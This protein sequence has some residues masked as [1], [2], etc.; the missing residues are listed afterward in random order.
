MNPVSSHLIIGCG[1]LGKRLA[2]LLD[3]QACWL[4]H[5]TAQLLKATGKS[6][7]HSLL[8]DINNE[9]SWACLNVLSNKPGLMIYCLVPPGQIDAGTFTRFIKQLNHLGSRRCVLVSSTVVYGNTER[10]VDADSDVELDNERARRQYQIEQEWLANLNH[11]SVVR[12]AG[13]YGPERVI[14]RNSI[15]N[16]DA[17]KGDPE[18]WLN[19][20]HVDDLASLLIRM[21]ELEQLEQ[22][23]L[24][25]DGSPVRRR[26]YYSYLAELLNQAQPKFNQD[27][28][29]RGAG[30]RCDN[31]LTITRT[32]WQPQHSDFQ[33]SLEKLIET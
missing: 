17:I 32:G 16:G 4:T 6:K 13:I 20:I 18:G 23:E 21:S 22:I 3:G 1:Y 19:L 26:D 28:H 30:R 15:M 8:L 14:G 12:S 24:A 31:K 33:R 25:C 10:M 2:G 11:A 27:S 5:R 7:T 29:S 9:A